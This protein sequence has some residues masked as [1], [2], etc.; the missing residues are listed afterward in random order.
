M[1]D[2][3][4]TRL[5]TLAKDFSY[6]E[7]PRIAQKVMARLQTRP[8]PRVLSCRLA[9]GIA[10]LLLLAGLMTVPPVRA[11]V[12]EFIRVGVVRIF[13]APEPAPTSEAP[14]TALPENMIP[15]TATPAL[16]ATSLI[17]F[18]ERM[19]GETT[20]EKARARV[21]FP[22]PLPTYPPDLG[23]PNHIFMQDTNSWMIVLVWLEPHQPEQVRMSLHVIEEG[24][25]VLEKYQPV[26]IQQTSVNGLTAVWTE[27][28]Y[29]LLMRN[30]NIEWR[31]LVKGH[32]LIWTDGEITYRLETNLPL[33]EAVRI[34]ESLQ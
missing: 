26:L 9:W 25:W 32:V 10:I 7:T 33:E 3:F 27:G 19:A 14:R 29:P 34:A 17:P 30:G 6:P 11:A 12:L 1:T 23:A 24:S 22:I 8:A 4:E 5:E 15:M 28:E 31:R 13:P 16:Q 18:L 2:P 20:L 21:G